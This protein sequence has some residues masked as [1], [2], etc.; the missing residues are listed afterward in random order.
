MLYVWKEKVSLPNK[1]I[2]LALI[3]HFCSACEFSQISIF[4]NNKYKIARVIYGLLT[5]YL[6]TG[7]NTNYGEIASLFRI[8]LFLF[9]SHCLQM[10]NLQ[11]PSVESDYLSLL[12]QL[13]YFSLMTV[14]SCHG[15]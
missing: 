1:F 7:L 5:C 13:Q 6:E 15:R 14:M 11:Y 9:P 3:D 12:A 4:I 2:I 8:D 10:D